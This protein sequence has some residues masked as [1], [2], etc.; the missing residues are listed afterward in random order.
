MILSN[1][2]GLTKGSHNKVTISC[3]F[4]VSKKCREVYQ[5]AYKD[6]L[7]YNIDNHGR[8]ICLYCSRKLKYSGRNNPN[9]KYTDIDDKYFDIIDSEE[10]A[11]LLGWIA[12][13][14]YVKE[15]GFSISINKKDRRCLL[16][17]ASLLSN[18]LTISE[19]PSKPDMI[20]LTINS[21]AIANN[22]IKLLKI[23]FGK[24]SN[25]VRFPE[26]ENDNLNWAFL[27]G[28]FDG[29][30]TIRK[31][32][33]KDRSPE[34]GIASDSHAMLHDIKDFCQIPCNLS[35]KHNYIF[36]YGN[37]ALDFLGKLYSNSSI[38][39]DRKYELYCIWSQYQPSVKKGCCID[40]KIKVQ[41]CHQDAVK[42]SKSR[43][44]D[45]G[46]D[47]TLIRK[48]KEENGIEYYGTGL[49]LC[50]IFGHHI[51]MFPRSSMPKNGYILANSVAVIDRTY[52][53]ELIVALIKFN[54]NAEPLESKLP[55]KMTQ[56]ISQPITHFE[57]EEVDNLQETERG[58]GGFGSSGR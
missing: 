54:P 17:L 25:K 8:D 56:I 5:S 43:I 16:K 40:N 24:K 45:S 13:D 41:Y 31:P 51:L 9:C 12:S 21:Q 18:Q 48:I 34:C 30:G 57:I 6:Y 42:P 36:W 7:R 50:P 55:I 32:S 20:Q 19:T 29:D 47:I 11:Y 26:L 37:N 33:F 44:S 38:Y 53:G 23:G 2:E 49:K 46:Y 52:V 1:I 4:K 27:R 10:K 28:Y 39:L 58:E 22:I 35:T 3:D 14:G 15:S